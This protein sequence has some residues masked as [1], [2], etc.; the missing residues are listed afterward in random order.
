MPVSVVEL[1][2]DWTQIASTR[3]CVTVLSPSDF[4]LSLNTEQSDETAL[5]SRPE[6]EEQF[7]QTERGQSLYAKGEGY[8]LRIDEVN[9]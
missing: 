9:T 6:A 5:L 3:C 4:A 7:R 1:T 2:D 8:T